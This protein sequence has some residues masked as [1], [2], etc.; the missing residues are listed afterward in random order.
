MA[1]PKIIGIAGS[2][3]GGKDT[4]ADYLVEHFNYRH[5]STGD[6]VREEAMRL[7][8][9]IER[10][11]LHEVANSMRYEF[12]AGYFAQKAL[13][14]L[15]DHPQAAGIVVSGL[16][17]LGEAKAIVQS[18]GAL[19]FVDAPVEMRYERMKARQ[20][21]DETLKTLEEFKEGESHEWYSG[22]TDADF[23]LRGIKAMA[24]LQVQNVSTL[25]VFLANARQQLE[26]PD[27]QK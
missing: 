25:E 9:S 20:R 19:L 16:R 4:L 24:P 22:D 1:A 17:S 14:K 6:M 7:K 10:P 23:N 18:G 21:D 15:G 27:T 13:D 11:V 3:A 26:L 12:G 2:F 5:Y 8:G